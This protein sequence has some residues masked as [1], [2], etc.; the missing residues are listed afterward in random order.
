MNN[1]KHQ[2]YEYLADDP[3]FKTLPIILSLII[4]AFFAIL[5][6]T[7][8]NIALTSLMKEFDITLPTVQWMTTGFM[9]IMGIVA[10]ISALLLQW[11]TTR[12]LFL[13][14]MTI[15][16]LGTVICAVA[17][18]FPILLIGRL[19]QAIGTGML[20]PI[21]FN[22]FL[23]IY[24]PFK[25]G[26]IM[27]I[28]GFVIMFAP[29]IG[30]TL[31]GVIVEYLGW[32]ALFIMVIP[33]SI[34][35]IAFASK[36]LINVSE[37]TK[38]KID[39]LSLVFSTIGFGAVI[40]GFSSAGKSE[41]GFLSINVLIPII[42]GI[43]GI[44]LFSIRQLNLK[45]P[46]IDLRVFKYPMYTHAILMFLIIIMTMFAS[47]I[48]LPIYMQ[49]P[50]AL[51]AATAGLILLP[52]SLLN[53]AMSP[54]MGYLFDKFGPRVLMIPA[55]IVL[56]GAMYVMSRLNVDTPLWIVIVSYILLMLSVSAIM[57]PAE[58]NGLNQLPKHLYPHGTAVMT[59]LQPV[60][61]AIGV[62]V[63]VSI[64]NARQLQFLQNSGKPQDPDTINQAMV[65][66]V[67]L[68]YF[69]SFSISIIAVILSFIV[70]R[71]TPK[72]TD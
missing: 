69:I 44:V 46:L 29:T 27:G 70:Y 3:N 45:E 53:G 57:M 41:S 61:G 8:L 4:G 10:P 32:R 71:A 7:L 34:F 19:I 25:R 47:E 49:G 66:G 16:T 68:V 28:V 23:L 20:L 60:T 30:P 17:P 14:T 48:I 24:P 2:K 39:Y 58:T 12:Q 56:S 21:I 50:L 62:A 42:V 6:E 26:K 52:G 43:I 36:F 38:P 59:T 37:V 9:L 11:F 72:K 13:S 1:N 55:S 54:F 18:A 22:V 33:F 64:M 63:F 65:A 35:S 15:F 51:T 31:S 40:Y 5:N 67:E